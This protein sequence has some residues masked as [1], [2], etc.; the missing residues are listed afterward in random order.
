V[1][2]K[3]FLF[4]LVL[5]NLLNSTIISAQILRNESKINIAG[6]FLVI[7][8]S[9][10]NELAGS[11]TLDGII[12]INGN[13][14]NNG[15]TNVITSPG[16]NGEVVFNGNA[17]QTISGSSSVF[18]FEKIT[19]NSGS[20]VQVAPGKGVT[21]YGACAFSTPLLLKSSTTLFRPIMATFINKSS[22]T[23][24]ITMELSY[25]ST[26]S[27]AAGAGRG[28]YLS[29]PI[30]N[31]TSTIFDVAAGSNLL[32][33][34]DEVNRV[35]K[36][37]ITNG[38]ALTVAKGYILRAPTS[39]VFNFTG[40]PNTSLSYGNSNIP[41]AVTGQFYLFGN[42][43][44]AVVD[45]QTIATKTNLS[46]TI[47]YQTSTDTGSMVVDTWNGASMIGTNNNGTAAV[48][49]KIPPMQSF[50]VQCSGVGLIGN[51][52][53]NESDRT[54][55]W[56]NSTFLKSSSSPSSDLNFLRLYLY[57]NE[58]R[59]EAVLLQSGMAKDSFDTWDSKK[60]LLKDGSRAEIY[61]LSPEKTNLVIQ[62][63]KPIEG[64]KD[65]KLGISIGT[66][67]QYRFIA[68]LENFSKSCNIYLEDKKISLMQDLM[69]NPEYIFN[70]NTIDDTSRFVIHLLSAPKIQINNPEEVCSPQ[71]IDLTSPSITSGSDQNLTFTYYTDQQ[72]TNQYYFPSTAE[73]GEYYIKG[74]AQ[75]GG[76]TISGPVTVKINPLPTVVANN[77]TAVI[78]PST[79]DLTSPAITLGSSDYLLY[80]Y[81]LDN[82]AT[83]PYTTPQNATQGDYYIKGT[84]E[85]TGC[86]S[87]AGPITVIINS[88]TT[89]I[90][91]EKDDLRLIYTSNNQLHILNCDL[92]SNIAVYDLLGCEKYIGTV[93]SQH[94]IINWPFKPGIYIVKVSSDK[95]IITKKVYI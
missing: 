50:W 11:I 56:G 92:Y 18:D 77:P 25:T 93:K 68:N 72:T 87:I 44:P 57:T 12:T 74:T 83:I 53:I 90:K 13:W 10:Q 91:F 38:A 40:T 3:T 75:N 62:S 86:F 80:S 30:A 31:A 61:S 17:T 43:Y 48:D 85:T 52:T 19:I 88:N 65:I 63:F 79:V 66:A 84:V 21:A 4:F 24:N 1:K 20:T 58:K 42:P 73:S 41:R 55:N 64:T 6:G 28:L 14:T 70:S 27:S 94:D 81:W 67:G 49:G 29:P 39:Q 89:D 60:M 5:I 54:H 26:G 76:Y 69:A 32:W 36:K 78:E 9:Y 47:W 46:N 51:L 23:G 95:T 35:Y 71:T 82:N 33:Y 8:G 16:T 22:V 2:S 15:S 7:S 37:V 59:D 34:Q 45:W